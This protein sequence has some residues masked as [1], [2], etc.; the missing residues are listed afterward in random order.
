MPWAAFSPFCFGPQGSRIHRIGDRLD[1]GRRRQM[2]LKWAEYRWRGWDPHRPILISVDGSDR[3]GYV[4][5]QREGRQLQ[6]RFLDP[7][8]PPPT[9][10][11]KKPEGVI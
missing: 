11:K 4:P 3:L 8:G 2:P 6:L 9:R 1:V 7:P 10:F 5:T